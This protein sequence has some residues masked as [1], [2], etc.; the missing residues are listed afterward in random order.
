VGEIGDEGE[1]MDKVKDKVENYLPGAFESLGKRLN[2]EAVGILKAPIKR[3]IVKTII[4]NGG[5]DEI[6]QKVRSL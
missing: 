1:G 2:A 4:D 3:K 6:V 5:N